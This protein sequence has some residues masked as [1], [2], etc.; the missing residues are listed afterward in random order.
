[1]TWTK[2]FTFIIFCL[3]MFLAGAVWNERAAGVVEGETFGQT[4]GRVFDR[5]LNQLGHEMGQLKDKASDKVQDKMAD[6][7]DTN[8]EADDVLP[9]PTVKKTT[10]KPQSGLAPVSSTTERL[11]TR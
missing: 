7:S 6:W 8:P 5:G 3:I 11:S 4:F 2:F 9:P 10:P 1:M